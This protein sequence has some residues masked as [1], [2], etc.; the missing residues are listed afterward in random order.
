MFD[1][2]QTNKEVNNQTVAQDTSL[3][4]SPPVGPLVFCSRLYI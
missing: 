1:E 3:L 4:E 2:A